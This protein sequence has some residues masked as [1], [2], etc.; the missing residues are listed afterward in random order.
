MPPTF[1]PPLPPD[2]VPGVAEVLDCDGD[3]G[4]LQLVD[5]GVLLPR[6]KESGVFNDPSGT[7]SER[8]IGLVVQKYLRLE[9]NKREI[10][11]MR[12]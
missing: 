5:A 2:G 10:K 9:T 3:E 4:R 1:A 8:D 11:Q 6:E 12:E 7:Y